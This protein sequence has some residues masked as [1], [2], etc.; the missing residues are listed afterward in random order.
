MP[1]AD[2]SVSR[3]PAS[4]LN[5]SPRIISL[6]LRAHSRLIFNEDERIGKWAQ[7]RMPNFVGWN[8]YYR[9]IGYERR[10]KLC[11]AVV[12]TNASQ[13]NIML[14]IVLE[15]PLT[16]MFLRAIF[17]YPFLQLGV[18]R[19]TSLIDASNAKSRVLAE[20][21]GFKPEGVLREA[22]GDGDTIVYGM[23]RRE[24]RWVPQ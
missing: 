5:G 20:H 10:G 9:A 1:Q 3:S 7:E 17:F 15:A 14:A 16:R 11:G 22:A 13:T 21:A 8:G 4:S 6:P 12:F 18:K 2:A 19:V 23:L 24:C